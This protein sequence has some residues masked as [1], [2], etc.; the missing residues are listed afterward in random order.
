[1]DAPRFH[2]EEI[3]FAERDVALR[4]PFRFGAAT[5]TACPQVTCGRASAS[6]TA[7]R[8]KALRPR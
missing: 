8:P 7:A 1:M 2:V 3:R 5:V 4:L 6:R